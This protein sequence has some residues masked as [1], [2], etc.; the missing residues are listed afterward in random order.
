[1]KK[2]LFWIASIALGAV[3]CTDKEMAPEDVATPGGSETEQAAPST[4]PMNHVSL[5]SFAGNQGRVTAFAGTRD[6]EL[7]P[8]EL[9]LIAEIENPSKSQTGVAGF[10]PEDGGR[11]L[12]ATCVYYNED[13][14]KYYVTYHM[15]GNNYNTQLDTDV[16]GFIE[17]FTIGDDGKIHLENIYRASNPSELDFDFNHLYFD[18]RKDHGDVRMEDYDQRLIA[19]GHLVKPTSTGKQDTQAIIG[20]LNLD[21][22]T[23]DYKVVYTG[24]KILDENGKSLGKVDA[25]DVNAVVRS[26]DTYYLATRKGIAL[27]RATAD[28]LFDASLDYDKKNY[29]V[30]TPGS[31]KHVVRC[32]N[33]E[34]RIS[35]LYLEK[36]FPNNFQY[37]DAINAKY[38]EFS[39]SNLQAQFIDP[40]FDGKSFGF[41]GGSKVMQY[42]DSENFLTYTNKAIDIKKPVSPID[43]KNVLFYKDSEVYAALGTGGLFYSQYSMGENII[44]YLGF[45]NRPVNGIFVDEGKD[46]ELHNG[47]IYVCN[48]SKLSIFNRSRHDEVASWNLPNKAD[49]SANYVTV[50]RDTEYNQFGTY[51]RIITVAFGQEGVKVFRFSPKNIY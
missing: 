39:I 34:S 2:H 24:E 27:L 40:E 51:D 12:S 26:Y 23:F 28:D 17:T 25:Q 14:G 10:V 30:K 47:F 42:I 16:A 43:G 21:N 22:N 31:V 15:Q 19:V 35:F 18:R 50:R 1:M 46:K 41:L 29:F 7:K 13:T 38:V 37:N 32:G 6:E 4:S 36:D 44:D 45:G 11:Y 49:G 33:D 9:R 20:N 48:G 8:G 5:A 3:A